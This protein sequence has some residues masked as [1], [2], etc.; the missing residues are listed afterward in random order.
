MRPTQ[1]AA[2][3]DYD[4]RNSFVTNLAD[5]AVYICLYVFQAATDDPHKDNHHRNNAEYNHVFHFVISRFD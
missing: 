1:A 5:R 3:E 2:I 4:K